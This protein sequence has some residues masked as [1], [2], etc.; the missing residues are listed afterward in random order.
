MKTFLEQPMRRSD[1]LKIGVAFAGAYF[2]FP[3][4]WLGGAPGC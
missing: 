4:A 2:L 1:F 3:R